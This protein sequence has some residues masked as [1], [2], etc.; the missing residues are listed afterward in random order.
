MNIDQIMTR[1]LVTVE[2]DDKLSVIKDIFDHLKFHHV[3]VVEHKRLV[4]VVS[5]R[6]LLKAI[7]PGVGTRTETTRDTATLTKRAHQVMTRTPVTLHPG[8]TLADA[9]GLFNAH[10]VSC[11]PV[12]DNDFKPVGIVSWRDILKALADTLPGAVPSAGTPD[13]QR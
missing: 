11:I 9:I 7:S 2:M 8:A 1:R 3:L 5:D 6:D 4:G 10:R 13:P 12:V